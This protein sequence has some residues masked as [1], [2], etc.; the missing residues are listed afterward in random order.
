VVPIDH[1]RYEDPKYV[2]TAAGIGYIAALE[3]LNT[4]IVLPDIEKDE[5]NSIDAYRDAVHSRIKSNQKANMANLNTAYEN[6]HILAYYRRGVGVHQM[7]KEGLQA[8]KYLIDLAE[9]QPDA[10]AARS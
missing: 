7:V 10:Q 5:P 1:N 3:A 8:V 9:S 6:L 2:Q 4:V